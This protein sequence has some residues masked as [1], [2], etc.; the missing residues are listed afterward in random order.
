MAWK[1]ICGYGVD[2]GV[3]MVLV[4]V[5]LLEVVLVLVLWEKVVVVLVLGGKAVGR[6]GSSFELRRGCR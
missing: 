6:H 1:N 5:L 3:L 4:M 2:M